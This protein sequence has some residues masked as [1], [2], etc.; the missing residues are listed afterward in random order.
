M[1]SRLTSKRSRYIVSNALL[2]PFQLEVTI[3]LAEGKEYSLDLDLCGEIVPEESKYEVLSTKIEIR[4][5]KVSTAQWPSLEDNG[6]GVC[7]NSF[8]ANETR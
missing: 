7:Y 1:P 3:Q 4:M 8:G 2:I 5:K 6:Q